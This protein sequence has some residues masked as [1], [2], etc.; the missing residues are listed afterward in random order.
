M[1]LSL[2]FAR[3]LYP[4]DAHRSHARV[5]DDSIHC[6]RADPRVGGP[7]APPRWHGRRSAVAVAGGAGAE[8]MTEVDARTRRARAEADVRAEVARAELEA[9]APAPPAL[10][11][12]RAR[13]AWAP[14]PWWGHR[15]H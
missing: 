9:P 13:A 7:A 12:L 15:A 3:S 8:F 11:V 2:S 6:P 5:R 1:L 4:H 14:P 10:A